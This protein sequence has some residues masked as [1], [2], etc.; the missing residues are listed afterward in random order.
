M[1]RGKK[2]NL[3]AKEEEILP[4]TQAYYTALPTGTIKWIRGCIVWQLIRF[5]VVNS[6]M[7]SMI[8]KSHPHPHKPGV[9]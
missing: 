5:I 3:A 2:P 8:G 4:Y 1:A 7:I 9:H 6:R